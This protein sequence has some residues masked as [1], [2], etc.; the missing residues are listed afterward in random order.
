MQLARREAT[1][2]YRFGTRLDSFILNVYN[3]NKELISSEQQYLYPE[4]LNQQLDVKSPIVDASAAEDIILNQLQLGELSLDILEVNPDIAIG[5]SG[6]VLELSVSARNL[7]TV[8]KSLPIFIGSLF[9]ILAT[10]NEEYGTYIVLCHLRVMD[11]NG[12]ILLD[13]VK[14]VEGGSA[15]W[16]SATGVNN[17]WFPIPNKYGNSQTSLTPTA[18]Q[19]SYPAPIE[20]SIAMHTPTPTSTYYF[21]PYP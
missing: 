6:Q 18:N 21:P 19:I 17:D 11:K 4:D 12:K 10:S 9:K 2:S 13:Y 5:G 3:S 15:Q 20:T 7:E 14:D 1:F 8:N 16:A